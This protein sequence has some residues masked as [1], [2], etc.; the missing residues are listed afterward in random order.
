MDIKHEELPDKSDEP[1]EP[2][3]WLAAGLS[4]VVPGMGQMCRGNESAGFGWLIFV[5]LGYMCFLVPG[6]VLHSCCVFCALM[7]GDRG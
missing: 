2:L 7:R 1:S 5:A 3:D 6:V 4:V